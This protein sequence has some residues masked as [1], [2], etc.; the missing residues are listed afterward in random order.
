MHPN[1]LAGEETDI[2]R[3]DHRMDTSGYILLIIVAVCVIALIFISRKQKALDRD[4]P[5][6][7]SVPAD[8]DGPKEETEE[9]P[10][11]PPQ[12]TI[13]EF[14][15]GTGKR[16]CPLRCTTLPLTVMRVLPH[17]LCVT[18]MKVRYTKNGPKW[19]GMISNSRI[20]KMKDTW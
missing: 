20:G 13:Y 11:G 9:E 19:A 12:N 6:V 5:I 18:V 7:P 4:Y 14:T 17:S 16:L 15:S 8:T 1:H 2:G 10:S 3:S